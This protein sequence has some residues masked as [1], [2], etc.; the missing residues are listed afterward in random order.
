[1]NEQ[2]RV[3]PLAQERLVARLRTRGFEPSNLRLGFKHTRSYSSYSY[4]PPLRQKM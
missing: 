3:K 1:M 4:P 2:E